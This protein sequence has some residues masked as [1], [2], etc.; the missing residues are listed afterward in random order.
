MSKHVVP[1]T[2]DVRLLVPINDPVSV[3]IPVYRAKTDG[4]MYPLYQVKTIER[5]GVEGVVL[6]WDRAT[7]RLIPSQFDSQIAPFIE[8][9]NK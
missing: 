6:N 5:Q 7:A 1:V 9:I 8:V 4:T 2:P 3:K